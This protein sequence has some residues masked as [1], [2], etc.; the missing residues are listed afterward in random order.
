MAAMPVML[1]VAACAFG[2]AILCVGRFITLIGRKHRIQVE[3]I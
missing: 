3:T 1:T 2:W